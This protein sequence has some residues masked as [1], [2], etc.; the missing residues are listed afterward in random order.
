M[1]IIIVGLILGF[2]S[3]FIADA[4]LSSA[5]YWGLFGAMVGGYALGSVVK[6]RLKKQPGP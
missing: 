2:V 5:A 6:A 1:I 3:G 4:F